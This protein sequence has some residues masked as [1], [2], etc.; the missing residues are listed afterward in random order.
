MTQ[1][2]IINRLARFARAV[3]RYLNASATPR[4]FD[5]YGEGERSPQSFTHKLFLS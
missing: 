2:I 3:R 1:I 5:T 4:G